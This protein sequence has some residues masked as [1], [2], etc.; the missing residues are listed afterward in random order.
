MLTELAYTG[1]RCDMI[2]FQPLAKLNMYQE[3]R[4]NMNFFSG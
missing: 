3:P 4:A 1:K 2:L